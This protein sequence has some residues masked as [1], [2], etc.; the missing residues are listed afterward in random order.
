MIEESY[1]LVL[2][3]CMCMHV[4]VCSRKCVHTQADVCL[5]VSKP[6]TSCL[7]SITRIPIFSDATRIGEMWPPGSVNTNFT[8]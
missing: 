7:V 2:Q 6:H 5:P 8:P 4:P 3:F 1:S